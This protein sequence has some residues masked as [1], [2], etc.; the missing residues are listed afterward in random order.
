MNTHQPLAGMVQVRL[1]VKP[2]AGQSLGLIKS[3]GWRCFVLAPTSGPSGL[4]TWIF[5]RGANAVMLSQSSAVAQIQ[6]VSL[7]CNDEALELC[8]LFVQSG[9]ALPA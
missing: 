3:K 4:F 9:L 8:S 6:T 7:P 1:Q 2:F 5:K